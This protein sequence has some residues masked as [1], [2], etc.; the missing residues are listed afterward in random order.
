MKKDLMVV[1]F[2]EDLDNESLEARLSKTI[3]LILNQN[4]KMLV[5]L[6]GGLSH[7]SI[8]VECLTPYNDNIHYII[9]INIFEENPAQLSC[10]ASNECK[11]VVD[12]ALDFIWSPAKALRQ[13]KQENISIVMLYIGFIFSVPMGTEI[14]S[15]NQLGYYKRDGFEDWEV[16][17]FTKLLGTK[18]P[19]W[20]CWTEPPIKKRTTQE[21]Q[22]LTELKW[23][24]R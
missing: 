13:M 17:R 16:K 2:R 6:K 10:F 15:V 24:S 18:N 5:L 4:K 12:I 19:P 8:V 9:Q 22:Q 11:Y 21:C 7:N 20:Q 3:D 14:C 23:F 1:E